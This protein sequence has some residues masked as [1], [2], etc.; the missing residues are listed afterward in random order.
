MED[1]KKILVIRIDGLG[2]TLLTIPLLK[3]LRQIYPSAKI[4]Y[5]AS[6]AASGVFHNLSLADEVLIIDYHKST[7]LEKIKF[8]RNLYHSRYSLCLNITEKIWGYIWA[9]FASSL[10]IGF[11]PGMSKPLKSVLIYPLMSHRIREGDIKLNLH[12]TERHLC[13][14]SPLG[15]SDIDP[16]DLQYDLNVRLEA[17]KTP[18]VNLGVS[19]G[20]Q[21]TE[22]WIDFGWDEGMLIELIKILNN[23]FKKHDIL[24]TYSAKEENLSTMIKAEFK[25]NGKV[26]FVKGVDF[27][28]WASSIKKNKC[29]VTMDSGSSHLASALG[30]FCIDVF[31]EEN[32]EYLTGRWHPWKSGHCLIKRKSIKNLSKDKINEYKEEFFKSIVNQIKEVIRN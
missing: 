15:Y 30:T 5:I 31:N 20:L 23:S 17:E 14:L 24:V 13:L 2:D 12:E 8:A 19:I 28:H 32:F 6:P 7:F 26:K 10:K 3:V 22:K 1:V 4:T 11:F 29:L 25:D 21:L 27:L 9:F 18:D 16:P